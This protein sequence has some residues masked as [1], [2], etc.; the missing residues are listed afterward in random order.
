MCDEADMAKLNMLLQNLCPRPTIEPVVCLIASTF[1]Y[2]L[3]AL[4]VFTETSD[5][6]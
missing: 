6:E 3:S 1:A 4:A 2:T 5:A